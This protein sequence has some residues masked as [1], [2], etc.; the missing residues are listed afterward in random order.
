MHTGDTPKLLVQGVTKVY[1]DGRR[2]L[3]VLRPIDLTV[4][5]SEFVTLIG[6]S[7]C[8]KSTLFNIIAGVDEPSA[9]QISFDG[10]SGTV[11]AG[12]SGY[13]RM[14]QQRPADPR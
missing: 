12:R 5:N 9:G 1:R 11:R 3:D 7:G 8:G 14:S 4:N 13:I 10:E 6:P 2:T